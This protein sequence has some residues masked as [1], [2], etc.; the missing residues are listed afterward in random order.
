MQNK[1]TP[2]PTAKQ[3]GIVEQ[4]TP[5]ES[6]SPSNLDTKGKENKEQNH[7]QD[8]SD[9]QTDGSDK[10]KKVN[11]QKWVPLEIDLAKSRGKRERSPKY[12][13]PREKNGESE[14]FFLS[15][16]QFNLIQFSLLQL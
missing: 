12:H 5:K 3:N 8:D 2:A 11:K 9:E 13:G 6:A 4:S 14:T 7:C 16:T 15:S 1:K 10:R